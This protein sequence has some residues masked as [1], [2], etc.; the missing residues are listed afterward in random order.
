MPR[1]A[2]FEAIAA[3]SLQMTRGFGSA[4]FDEFRRGPE[5]ATAQCDTVRASERCVRSARSRKERGDAAQGALLDASQ[6]S[7]A[8]ATFDH[9]MRFSF[10]AF[11]ERASAVAV[12][13]LFFVDFAGWRARCRV[14]RTRRCFLILKVLRAH[15][16]GA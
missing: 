13:G 8:Q 7:L 14:F 3:R 12:G 4:R 1:A 11:P 2:S 15:Q 16:R 5:R 10:D 6:R 9:A